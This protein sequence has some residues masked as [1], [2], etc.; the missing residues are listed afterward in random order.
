ML[1]P[2]MRTSSIFNTRPNDR[3]IST[4]HMP[5]LLAH[6]LH[7]TAK[8]SQHLNATYPNIVGS[9]MLRASDHRVAT[10]WV[11][12]IE[13]VRMLWHNVVART[14]PNDYNI[15]PHPQMLHEKIDQ[16]QI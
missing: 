14:W 5:A 2:G 11:L 15:M 1:R 16:F 10:F 7:A 12:K 13:L 4:Q 6:H 3:N 8:R 9:N